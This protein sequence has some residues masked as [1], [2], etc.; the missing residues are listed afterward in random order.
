MTTRARKLR[1]AQNVIRD[2]NPYFR[3]N[4]DSDVCRIG[5]KVLWIHSFVGVS[6]FA[7]HRKNRP[8]T[9]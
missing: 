6:H 3:I 7:K 2:S 1:Q 9:V 5:P 8:V 4:P